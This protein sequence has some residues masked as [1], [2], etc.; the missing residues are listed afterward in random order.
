MRLL[1]SAVVV[2][3]AL[4]GGGWGCAAKATREDCAK[5]CDNVTRLYLGAVERESRSDE[6]LEGMGEEGATMA[7]EMATLQL[8]FLSQECQRECV[9]KPATA[10]QAECLMNAQTTDDLNKCM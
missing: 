5:A 7:R 4:G 9:S 8:D 6:V 3:V 10:E 2:V 1:L